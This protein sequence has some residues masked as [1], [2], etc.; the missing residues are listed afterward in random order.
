M[1]IYNSV[2]IVSNTVVVLLGAKFQLLKVKCSCNLFITILC[3]K[4]SLTR[5]IL[6]KCP[7]C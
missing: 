5:L 1:N 6:Y 7:L 2:W 4:F 3:V